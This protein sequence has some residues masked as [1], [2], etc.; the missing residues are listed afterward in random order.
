MS[1]S[2]CLAS[3]IFLISSSRRRWRTLSS[4]SAAITAFADPS[5]NFGLQLKMLDARPAAE[6]DQHGRTTHDNDLRAG[7]NGA[8]LNMVGANI[9]YPAGQHDGFVIATQLVPRGARYP[10]LEGTEIPQQIG[11]AEFVVECRRSQ[12]RLGRDRGHLHRGRGA[13]AGLSV[14]VRS[15]PVRRRDVL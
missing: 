9:P 6:T 11:P 14:A 15:S 7:W 13:G 2:T 12:R 10:F 3:S 5:V 4:F 1:C 8:F